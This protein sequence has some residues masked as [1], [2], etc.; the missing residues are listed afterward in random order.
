MATA[1]ILT[2]GNE[3]VSG[4]VPNTNGSWLAKRLAPLGVSVRMLAAL[5]DEIEQI[6]EF[7]ATRPRA[8]TS[9]S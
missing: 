9:C 4:D 7:V 1:S 8:S 5:P 3:L 2:I 6:A